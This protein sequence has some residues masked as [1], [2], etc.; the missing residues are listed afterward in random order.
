MLLCSLICYG[1]VLGC[2]LFRFVSWCFVP[3]RVRP[4]CFVSLCFVSCRFFS[5]RFVLFRFRFASFCL[6]CVV[7]VVGCDC[8]ILVCCVL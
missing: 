1:G 2:V 6:V 3:L 4:L 7:G 8:S 5:S